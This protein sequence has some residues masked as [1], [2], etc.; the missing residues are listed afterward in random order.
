[1]F[2]SGTFFF[3][4]KINKSRNTGKQYCSILQMHWAI[5]LAEETNRQTVSVELN[6]KFSTLKDLLLPCNEG[7]RER[8]GGDNQKR[9]PHMI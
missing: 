2:L 6:I 8:D 5:M 3:V 9:I 4:V 7:E 1:M